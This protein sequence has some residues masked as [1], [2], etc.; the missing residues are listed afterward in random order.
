[1]N[2]HSDLGGY[3]M[4]PSKKDAVL[5][6][7]E[8]KN[9]VFA[10]AGSY[11]GTPDEGAY[12]YIN[13]VQHETVVFKFSVGP[14][15]EPVFTQVAETPEKTA[16]VLGVGHG[17][18]TSL[19]GQPGTGLYWVTDIQGL[20]LRIYDAVPQ[21]GKLNL[22]KG[23]NVPGQIKFSRPT[24]GNGRVYLTTSTGDLVMVGSPVNPPLLCT[25]PIQFGEVTIG[26]PAGIEM[27]VSCR[28]N[29]ATT[30]TSIGLRVKTDFTLANVSTLPRAM[31][32]GQNITF[33]A[34][35]FPKAPGPLSDDVQ[36]GTTNGVA[37]YA[38]NTP[39]AL[40]GI[41]RS[42]N[43]I[44]FISPNTVSFPGIITGENTD[45][46]ERS[47]VL[48][49]QGDTELVISDYD[50]SSVSESGPWLPEGSTVAGPFTF[51]VLP[52]SIPAR[53]SI[54]I[55]V[56]FNPTENGNYGAY[57]L[58][59]SNG[60]NRFVTIVGT[61]G[62]YPKAK[63]EFEKP[64]GSG[65]VEFE[66]DNPDFAFDFGTVYQQKTKTLRLRLTN[67]G[68]PGDGILGVT[69]SKPPIGASQVVGARN[70]VDLGEGT[71]LLPGESATAALFCSVPKSQINV[72]S[73]MANATWTMNL[74]DPVFGKHDLKFICH[75][76][77]EQGGPLS[78]NGQGRYRYLGCF[79]E[80][81]PGRQLES[82]LYGTDTLTNGQCMQDCFNSARN[83]MFVGTQYHR[84]CW[85]GNSLPTLR[86]GDE[87]CNF[88][89]TG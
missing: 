43:P 63:L 18:T 79:K 77:A 9:S 29:I 33:K 88:D 69:V 8:L 13:V 10:T 12:V 4:G 56:N 21:D 66:K 89:C 32:A 78:P 41:G 87:D 64:D 31:T 67:A 37:N 86:V 35:F 46:V 23:L 25:S 24:F 45:G 11:P 2:T 27:E 6:V 49:N 22:I 5:Q 80:N 65:W 47:F 62:G 15:G 3:Q 71:Q 7:V 81:N 70:G 84:E 72:G 16:F 68:N 59:R 83:F 34:T 20:N 17:T 61:S 52:T 39:V 40:R 28:A 60:G 85:C 30:V 75:A 76:A 82:Q 38:T 48:Y 51:P 57:L 14:N 58:F 74:G 19:N 44:L 36:I 1:M 55:N 42:L 54:T 73:Y 26:D 53:G 50:L